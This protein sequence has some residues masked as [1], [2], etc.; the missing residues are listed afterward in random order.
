M[1]EI[2]KPSQVAA[3]LQVHVKTVYRIAEHGEIPGKRI[4]RSWRFSKTDIL[5]LA[6]HKP[7]KEPIA[8]ANGNEGQNRHK[9]QRRVLLQEIT[10]AITSTLDLRGVLEMLMEKVDLLLPYTVVLVWLVNRESGDL[11]RTVCRN[12]DEKEWKGRN[13]SDIPDLPKA[14]VKNKVPVVVINI[15]TDPRTRDPGFFRSQGL[16]SHLGVPLIA[17]GEVLGVLSFFTREEHQFSDE[18]IEFLS[19]LA[20]QAAIAIHNSQLYDQLKRRTHELSALHAV[21][22][23]ASQSLELEPVLQEVIKK[24]TEI[25]QFDATRIFLFN[26]QM[27]ELHL[28]AS[29]EAKPEFLA[30][31]QCFQWGKGNVGKVA[32]TGEPMIFEDIKSDPR[33]LKISQSKVAQKAGFSFFAVFPIKTKLRTV[34]TIVCIGQMPRSLTPDETQLITSMAG[35]I[36]VTVE[37]ANLFQETVVRAKELSTLYS[38]ATVVNQYLDVDSIMRSVMQ[39]VLEIFDFDA[40]RTYLANSSGEELQ[41]VSHTGSSKELLPSMSYRSG[42]GITGMVFKGGEPILFEDIQ[43]DPEFRKLSQSRVLLKGGF[44]GLFSIPIATKGKIIGV[45]NFASKNPHRFSPEEVRLIRSIASHVGIAVEN[46]TLYRMSRRREEIQA[47]LKEFSQDITSLNIDNLLKKLTDK[48]R[49]VFQVDICD[50]RVKGEK[51]WQVP[52]VLG[53]EADRVRSGSTGSSRGRSSWIIKNRK[54]LSIPDITK[55]TEIPIGETTR[56]IGARS[57]L[58]VPL[59]TR[60]GEVVAVLRAMTYQPREYTEEEVQLLQQLANGTAIAMENASLFQEVRQKSGELEALVKINKDIAALLDRDVLLPRIAEEARMLLKAEG[61]NFR[62]VEGEFLEHYS[63]IH[64]EGVRFRPRL[65]LGESL[66]GRIIR[67]NRVVVIRHVAEDSTII[68]EHREKL[69]KAGFHA[70]LGV[71]LQI[72]GRVVGA[73]NLYC[74]EE[75]EFSN[76]DVTMISAF[77]D[78]AAIAVENSQLY[79]RTKKQALQ[80]RKDVEELKGAE[81][82]IRKLNEGLEQRVLQRTSELEAANKELEAF[83]YSVSHDLRAPLRAIDGFSRILIEEHAP[84]LLPEC[85]RYLR[86]VHDNAQQMGCLIDDLLTFSRLNRQPVKKQT[87]AP[88]KL[89]QE[90]L[91][92]LRSEQGERRFEITVG[93]LPVCQGDPALLKLVFINLLS[94]AFKFTRRREV[95]EI[96]IGCREEDDERI[97]FV[98]DNGVAFDMK[99]IDK[100]FGVFQRLHRAEDY[101]GTGVGLATVQ[102]IIHRHGGRVWASAKL[103]E[104]ATFYF[105]LERGTR[106]D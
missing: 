47:L 9:M 25:F 87:V 55:E 24:I 91:K 32:E 6:T 105:T 43:N 34:G 10:Q 51:T 75:R 5:D 72:G 53:I 14:V 42:D 73:I 84:Q 106:H 81:E 60:G 74:K 21:T 92:D 77:A 58:G 63:S 102:R 57:Y 40:A 3:L 94:N 59:M 66:T 15:Q 30:Q 70:Y 33:Y 27:N 101:E 31:V 103:N 68:E 56:R 35:Q 82:E 83:S 18:E 11:E 19:V 20:G 88:A 96:E 98:R 7:V 29:F 97:Y 37:N 16:M 71:P 69:R 38:V 61:S 86:L 8:K 46:A 90:V 54:P 93:D 85:Q 52:G 22:T 45:M 4:G 62:L 2:L 80:L 76:E 49:E 12:L 13:P 48:V 23:A 44:R 65:R 78:Q 26:P 50:V 79:E 36:G 99:Y 67:E 100:L 39:K 95:A 104:G 41:L 64:G 28:R 89:V 1:E 17:K